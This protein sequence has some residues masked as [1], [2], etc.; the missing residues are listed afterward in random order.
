MINFKSFQNLYSQ[1]KLKDIRLYEALDKISDYLQQLIT[2][3]NNFVSFTLTFPAPLTAN[4]T[5]QALTLAYA[6]VNDL[7]FTLNKSGTWL[8]ILDANFNQ[9]TPDFVIDT[10][11]LVNGVIQFPIMQVDDGGVIT[12]ASIVNASKTCIYKSLAGSDIVTVQVKKVAGAG[13]SVITNLTTMIG[14]WYP[15]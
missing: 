3:V 9:Y 1:V 7:T 11:V 14:L 10:Q 15:G 6:N 4:A 5:G 2:A 13:T 8:I 12:G